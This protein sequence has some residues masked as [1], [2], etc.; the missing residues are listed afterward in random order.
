[1]AGNWSCRRGG[2]LDQC[3][4]V[5]ATLIMSRADM[6]LEMALVLK[7][8]VAQATYLPKLLGFS[9]HV[10]RI[11]LVWFM[12]PECVSVEGAFW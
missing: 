4:F 1:M 10:P 9:F 8:F 2:Y 5:V 12:L 3:A 6:G 11:F 7:S